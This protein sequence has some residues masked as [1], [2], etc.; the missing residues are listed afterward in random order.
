MVFL[1]LSRLHTSVPTGVL[2][3]A[4]SSQLRDLPRW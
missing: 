2:Q 1:E 3:A 4:C